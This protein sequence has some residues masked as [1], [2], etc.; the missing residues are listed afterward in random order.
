MNSLALPILL[1]P[2]QVAQVLNIS[3]R[4]LHTLCRRR[5][6]R[7]IKIGGQLRFEAEDLTDYI[8]SCKKGIRQF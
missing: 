7:F 8:R 5:K 1:K 2:G 3:P 6:I 4:T